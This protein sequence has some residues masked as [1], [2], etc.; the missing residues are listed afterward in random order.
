MQAIHRGDIKGVKIAYTECITYEEY[1]S[2]MFA[3]N[4]P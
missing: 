3:S 4:I 1:E 2:T